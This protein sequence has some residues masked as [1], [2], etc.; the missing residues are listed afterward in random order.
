MSIE[1]TFLLR[2]DEALKNWISGITVSD[3][4]SSARSVKTWFTMPDIE[5]Q[6]MTFPF[7]TLDLIDMVQSKERQV[8]GGTIYSNDLGGQ[9]VANPNIVYSYDAPVAWDLYYQIS[10]YS[11]HPR[12][13]REIMKQMLQTYTPGKWGFLPLPN[14]DGSVYEWRHMFMESYAKRDTIVDNRR[15]YRNIITVRVLTEMTQDAST[16]AALAL[17][18]TVNITTDPTTIPTG[19][20]PIQQTVTST[21]I[22]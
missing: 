11:R 17:V 10:T 19:F 3:G 13:D 9:V 8:G 16:A 6:S 14:S 7:I 12:H 5:L 15:L 2:E 4:K 22:G 20:T 1:T 21:S 18:Q